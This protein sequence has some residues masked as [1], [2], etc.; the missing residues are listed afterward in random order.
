MCHR[1]EELWGKSVPSRVISHH[2]L[3][4]RAVNA[5]RV[6]MRVWIQ[7]KLHTPPGATLN[8]VS[9]RGSLLTCRLLFVGQKME[10]YAISMSGFLV[11]QL[12]YILVSASMWYN[13]RL[14]FQLWLLFISRNLIFRF[15]GHHA[16]K[17]NG[18][19]GLKT[20]HILDFVIRLK[21]T[22]EITFQ[23][24]YCQG[25]HPRYSL[26]WPQNQ[27]NGNEK[28]ADYLARS[29]KL[30]LALDSTVVLSFMPRREPWPNFC[31]FQDHLC[32][33]KWGLLFD[34]RKGWSFWVGATFVAP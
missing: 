33:W 21:C 13:S 17:A 23:T 5:D 27:A 22:V 20:P 9:G 8:W 18:G 1:C 28:Y 26:C 15:S 31:S 6:R 25:N 10:L 30:L 12:R 19:R 34:E 4:L 32:I 11:I 7:A 29:S 3:L 16:M 24:H 2:Q 14:Q